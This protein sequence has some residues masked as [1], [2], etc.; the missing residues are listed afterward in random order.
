MATVVADLPHSAPGRGVERADLAADRDGRGRDHAVRRG[1]HRPDPARGHRTGR[2]PSCVV[3]RLRSRS[4]GT[5]TSTTPTSSG[6]LDPNTA[7]RRGDAQCLHRAAARC[8]LRRLRR[9]RARAHRARR[10]CQRVRTCD[11]AAA[12]ARGPVCRRGR[13]GDV[14]RHRHPDWVRA[15]LRDLPKEMNRSTQLAHRY[16]RMVFD[17]VEAAILADEWARRSRRRRRSRRQEPEQGPV[18]LDRAGGRGPGR[19][20]SARCRSAG[21]P[22]PPGRGRPSSPHRPLRARA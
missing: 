20:R 7:D 15:K 19:V 12:T 6:S 1:R 5:P 17:L 8:G 16:E 13:G 18:M 2:W 14:C 11:G 10:A 3:P 9:W 4:T 21:R 22:G